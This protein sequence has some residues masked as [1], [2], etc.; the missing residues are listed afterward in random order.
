MSIKGR[1]NLYGSFVYVVTQ[2]SKLNC[3]MFLSAGKQKCCHNIINLSKKTFT[4][5]EL[6]LLNKDLNFYQTQGKYNKSKYA[7]DIHDFIRRKRLKTYFKVAQ[8]LSKKDITQFIKKL[9]WKKVDPKRN[10]SHCK[11]VY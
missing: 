6:K 2:S 7:I 3:A 1:V 8:L 10:T 9:F 4:Y 5:N 11:N